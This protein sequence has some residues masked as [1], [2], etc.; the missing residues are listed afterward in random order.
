MFDYKFKLTTVEQ[1]SL[2]NK[3]NFKWITALLG[4]LIIFII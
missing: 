4:S 1:I 2:T 3:A